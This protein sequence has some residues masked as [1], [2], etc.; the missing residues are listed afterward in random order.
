MSGTFAEFMR[1]KQIYSDQKREIVY[2]SLHYPNYGAIVLLFTS[3][4]AE[5]N[6]GFLCDCK[7]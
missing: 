6:Y 4:T 5:T 7:L 1:G 3:R 2:V